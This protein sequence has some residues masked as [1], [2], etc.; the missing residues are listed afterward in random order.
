M[1]VFLHH[2]MLFF[3][4]FASRLS[5]PSYLD[6]WLKIGYYLL[7]TGNV[8][9]QSLHGI[10]SYA[11]KDAEY[12]LRQQQPHLIRP[13]YFPKAEGF[14]LSTSIFNV[15]LMPNHAFSFSVLFP[16]DELTSFM[17]KPNLSPDITRYFI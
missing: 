5:L 2:A 15:P 13:K 16:I 11:G 9:K 12:I 17:L 1:F 3:I 6:V 4:N 8:R 10:F 7:I 14:K